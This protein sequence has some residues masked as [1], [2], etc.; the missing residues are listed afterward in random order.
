METS[1]H[2]DKGLILMHLRM[3][4]M[5][6]EALN[7]QM[8]SRKNHAAYAEGLTSHVQN[9]LW[10]ASLSISELQTGKGNIIDYIRRRHA[11]AAHLSESGVAGA[12]ESVYYHE[13]KL[14]SL[15]SDTIEELGSQMGDDIELDMLKGKPSRSSSV[16]SS[17]HR[18]HERFRMA[19]KPTPSTKGQQTSRQTTGKSLHMNGR[20]SHS[21][22][23]FDSSVVPRGGCAQKAE[24][25]WGFGDQRRTADGHRR[26][27]MGGGGGQNEMGSFQVKFLLRFKQVRNQDKSGVQ[28]KELIAL[29]STHCEWILSS[30]D[31]PFRKMVMRFVSDMKQSRSIAA[32]KSSDPWGK[33]SAKTASRE[34]DEVVKKRTL[35]EHLLQVSEFVNTLALT[36]W[37]MHGT[38]QSRRD[39]APMREMFV[40]ACVKII[41]P[42]VL[43]DLESIIFEWY[44]EVY[45]TASADLL[46]Y[47]T[48]LRKESDGRCTEGSSG[49]EELEEGRG[50]ADR[51]ETANATR[52]EHEL[53]AKRLKPLTLI[54]KSGQF[55]NNGGLKGKIDCLLALIHDVPNVFPRGHC[56]N[57]DS[58]LSVIAF[59]LIA[60]DIPEICAHVHFLADMVMLVY[61]EDALG[62]LGCSVTSLVCAAQ[63]GAG[64]DAE[65]YA[66]LVRS[67]YTEVSGEGH[68][69]DARS[70]VPPDVKDI[71]RSDSGLKDTSDL[72]AVCQHAAKHVGKRSEKANQRRLFLVAKELTR[73]LYV[74]KISTSPRD[75]IFLGQTLEAYGIIRPYDPNRKECSS[76]SM[77][78]GSVLEA[79]VDIKA[80]CE[81]KLHFAANATNWEVVGKFGEAGQRARTAFQY[82]VQ[83]LAAMWRRRKSLGFAAP[84]VDFEKEDS[85]KGM[86]KE[87]QKKK[88][89]GW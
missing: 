49:G 40:P 57:A 29:V 12:D 11:S 68:T 9:L 85:K 41:W 19:A 10:F 33:A 13:G 30:E 87:K 48:N 4:Q 18:H 54:L 31:L 83:N 53:V 79:E 28:R 51:R 76:S 32:A 21:A 50:G 27:S 24:S 63:Y 75:A 73:H 42:V 45:K 61:S 56:A 74:T 17:S 22:V 81:K 71:S 6:T 47:W 89:S 23:S 38:L 84:F 16:S 43:K 3:L 15:R 46:E 67:I 39:P 37:R 60:A 58:L 66:E 59:S 20:R 77:G 52:K 2:S 86:K 35:R 25:S 82:S 65:N 80:M 64:L 62:E 7:Q 88:K 70:T 5:V 55:L 34:R 14:D 78:S 8:L 44:R 69:E 72:I 36:M 26:M 1:L